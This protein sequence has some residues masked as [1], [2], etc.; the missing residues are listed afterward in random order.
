MKINYSIFRSKLIRTTLNKMLM[1]C[2]FVLIT[3]NFSNAQYCTASH[4]NGGNCSTADMITN[5]NIQ[6]TT[7]DNSVSTCNG[8]SRTNSYSANGNTTATLY[9]TTN[10]NTY[11]ISVTSS[12]SAIMSVWIDYDQSGTFDASEWVQITTSSTANQAATNTITVPANALL[13]QTGMRVRTRLSGNQNGSG[14]ACLAMGSGMAHDYTVTIDTLAPCSGTPTAGSVFSQKDSICPGIN[15]NL[16]VSGGTFGSGQ[17]FQWQS[18]SDGTTWTNINGATKKTLTVSITADTYYRFYTE[19]SGSADTASSKLIYL[20]PFYN[21]YCKSASNSTLD[22][23]IG[24]FIFGNFSNGLDSLPALSNST[25]VNTYSDFTNLT[26]D[27][28]DANSKYFMQVTQINSSATFY[29]CHAKVYIDY[30]QDGQFDESSERVMLQRTYSRATVAYG[31]VVGDSVLIPSSAEN[32]VTR[33]RV[34]LM[35]TTNPALVN[36]C[37]N[38]GYGETEDYLVYI[39][40]PQC[41]ATPTAGTAVSSLDSVC[42]ATVFNLSLNSNTYGNGQTYQWQSSSNGTSWTNITG[43]TKA[44]FATTQSS[45]LSYR[46]YITCSGN[47]DTSSTVTVITKKIADCYCKP[48]YTTGSGSGDFISSVVLANA[49]NNQ[50]GASAAPY[51]NYY[52]GAGSPLL[53]GQTYSLDVAPGSYNGA[54][55]N[56]A[57]WIDYNL[58]GTFEASEKLGQLNNMAANTAGSITFTIPTGVTSG[59]N[60]LRVREVFNNTNIDPC[61]SATFGETEDYDIILINP[62]AIDAGIRSVTAPGDYA[63][64]SNA[65]PVSVLLENVGTDTLDF[66]VHNLQVTVNVS[67]GTTATLDTIITSGIMAPNDTMTVNFAGTLDL[68]SLASS[69]D[70][71]IY[72]VTAGDSD[73]FNDTS[74]FTINTVQPITQD[75]IEDFNT[76]ANIP[77]SYTSNNLITSAITGVGGTRCLRANMTAARPVAFGNTPIVGPLTSKSVFKFSYRASSQLGQDDSI[78]VYL[79][80]D[81]GKTFNQVFNINSNNTNFNSYQDFVYDLGNNAGS[82]VSAV[83]LSIDNSATAYFVDIDNVLIAEKPTIDL[84]PDTSSCSDVLLNANPTSNANYSVEW[85]TGSTYDTL[86]TYATGLYYATITDFITGLTSTD[87]IQVNIYTAPTVNLGSNITACGG[88]SVSLDAGNFGAGYKYLWNT[89]DTTQKIN[90]TNAGNY[91]VDVITPGGCSGNGSISVAFTPAPMG[92]SIIKGNP[93][94]GNFNNGTSGNPDGVCIGSSVKYELTPPTQFGNGGFGTTW[95]IKSLSI[96]TINGTTP[97][98]GTYSVSAPGASNAT[99]TFSPTNAEADSIYIIMISV[100]DSAVGCDTVVSRFIKVNALPKPSIS[101]QT[102]CPNSSANFNGGSY[103]SYLWSDGTSSSTFSTSTAGSVWVKVTDAN[104]CVNSDTANVSIFNVTPVNLGADK[105]YCPGTSASIDAGQGSQFAWNTGAST[106]SISV[107]T[108]GTYFVD[109]T[110]ANGCVSRDSIK[111]SLLTAPSGAFTSSRLQSLSTNVQ[112]T[113]TDVAAGNSYNWDFGDA[114]NSSQQNPIHIYATNGTYNVKLIVTNTNSCK[115]SSS[116][117][118]VINSNIQSISTSVNGIEVYP[119]PYNGNTTLNYTITE[120]SLINIEIFD[121]TGRKIATLLNAKQS[122]GNYQLPI[123]TGNQL[124]GGVYTIRLTA[125]GETLSLRIVDI[126]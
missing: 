12:S 26:P 72:A 111:I 68:S 18:S 33:L 66:S 43:A 29:T 57:A 59:Y 27:T 54:G 110:D 65:E 16:S 105:G 119:N 42:P 89:G 46:C 77:A 62:F 55:N 124:S 24:R 22:D 47:T 67:G 125:N 101:D 114:S 3:A 53:I 71:L 103:S 112:F 85:N 117:S 90:V 121:I 69:Y 122:A 45:N 28:F 74:K 97:S 104:G 116:T 58:N 15:L 5:V 2:M 95:I 6:G 8:V 50:T 126:K 102:I 83:F 11:T 86:N 123:N 82:N 63:C 109:V 99:L 92:V 20:N 14:D 36:S 25:S 61:A 115:D 106:Q 76:A 78:A 19:C 35:E 13:G 96:A 34:V 49:I 9:R 100:K 108:A 56:I 91:S 79:T 30:N 93:Y 40:L 51:Y 107:N 48:T 118:T 88:T 7:L 39:R 80:F 41:N 1:A 52:S 23:D 87:S 70:F 31:N 113:A 120:S 60:I 17:T 98:L 37:G 64:Y 44:S 73:A 21:C 81:C 32:G 84:G 4:T 10:F 38:Y 94:N 75:Y